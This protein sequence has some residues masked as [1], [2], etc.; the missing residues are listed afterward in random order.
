M[1]LLI[2]TLAV[3]YLNPVLQDKAMSTY[4]YVRRF[5]LLICAHGTGITQHV[6]LYLEAPSAV[7]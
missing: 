1:R 7:L 2:H 6:W 5:V 3:Q 4:Q